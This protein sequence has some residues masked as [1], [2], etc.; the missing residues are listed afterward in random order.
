MT[1][2]I[3]V[4]IARTIAFA[5][6]LREMM[7]V[8]S[9]HGEI[10]PQRTIPSRYLARGAAIA[11]AKLAGRFAYLAGVEDVE[12][13]IAGEA[14]RQYH[15]SADTV[16]A[17]EGEDAHHA[18]STLRIRIMNGGGISPVAAAMEMLDELIRTRQFGKHDPSL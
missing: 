4:G 2:P 18:N 5:G 8:L 12:G 16:L 7:R 1:L 10:M 14:L 13:E 11:C 3:D 15:E 9:P 6:I 17:L